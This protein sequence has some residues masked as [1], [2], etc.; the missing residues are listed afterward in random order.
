MK[1]KF[2]LVLSVLAFALGLA[3]TSARAA[4]IVGTWRLQSWIEEETE[5]KVVHNVFGEHPLGFITFTADKRVAV[6]FVDPTRKAPAAPKA[7][8]A[9]ATELYRTMVA[10]AGS[11]SVEG[12]KLTNKVEVAWNQAWNGTNQVRFFDLKDDRLTVRTQAFMSP[13]LN[14]QIV[15][16]LVFERLK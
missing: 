13:F 11:Y 10:Y 3:T 8:D 2:G 14:K 5:S 1:M 6:I 7:T 9:E 12:D 4:D 16:T 15:S